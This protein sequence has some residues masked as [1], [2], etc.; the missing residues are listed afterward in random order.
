MSIAYPFAIY[1][2]MGVFLGTLSNLAQDDI[3]NRSQLNALAIWILFWP[4]YLLVTI[5]IFIYIG[6]KINK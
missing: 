3:K 2:L 4:F 6:S 1:L 5:I